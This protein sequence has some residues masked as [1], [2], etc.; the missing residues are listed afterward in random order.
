VLK[1]EPQALT[2]QNVTMFPVL[3]RIS[4]ESALLRPGM[5][6]EVEIHIG[7]RTGVLAV[8]NVALRTLGDV[9]SAAAVLGLDMET[10]EAQLAGPPPQDRGGRA[11]AAADSEDDGPSGVMVSFRGQE[12][13]LPAGLTLDEVTPV[14]EKLQ[15]GREAMRS[16]SDAEREILGRLRE[17][18]GGGGGPPRNFNRVEQTTPTGVFEFGGDYIVF[19]MRDGVPTATSIRTGLT[20]LDYSEV[21]RGLSATD[22][23]VVLSAAGSSGGQQRGGGGPPGR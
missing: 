10:V 17:A 21:L 7:S 4:N 20:D 16:L 14:L 12:V 5:N 3:I 1:I 2:E 19:V 9:A 15:G 23:I 13:P 8:P 6:S 11:L 22:S 18:A